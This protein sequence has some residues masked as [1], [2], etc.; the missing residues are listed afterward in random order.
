MTHVTAG[1]LELRNHWFLYA[2]AFGIVFGILAGASAGS[3]AGSLIF[4]GYGTVL[5][6]L[7]GS[8][9]GGFAGLLG[10]PAAARGARSGSTAAES[11]AIAKHYAS[12]TVITFAALLAGLFSYASLT[13]GVGGNDSPLLYL[14]GSVLLIVAARFGARWAAYKVLRRVVTPGTRKQLESLPSGRKD[15]WRMAL[16]C[17]APGI[18]LWTIILLAQL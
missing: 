18:L 1:E 5:G 4:P 7:F 6:A 10:G 15:F 17:S 11:L 2:A 8:I 3:I 16:T 9:G 14:A 12:V 13:D